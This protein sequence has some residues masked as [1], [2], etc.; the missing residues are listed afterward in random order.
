MTVEGSASLS[1]ATPAVAAGERRIDRIFADLRAAGRTGLMPFITGGF[2][3]LDATPALLA[4]MARSEASVVEVG[5]PFSDPIA[6]G[7]V[8]AASMHEALERGFRVPAL[9]DCIREL[10]P[11]LGGLGLV[12]M[13]S[14]S[15]VHRV[16]LPR[17]VDQAAEAG[18]DG[19]IFPD[20]PID[21]ATDAVAVAGRAGLT[22]S[23]LIAPTTPSDRAV[24]IADASSGFVYL[25]ARLGITGE[26]SDTPQI[27]ARM[28]ELRTRSALPV[29]CGFGIATAEAVRAVTAVADAAIVGS[30]LVRRM[31]EH[32]HEGGPMAELV[33]EAGAFVRELA[34]GLSVRRV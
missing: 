7:P 22:C 29:A 6:D 33:A 30:A 26:R 25:M 28:R 34:G 21:E 11:N 18:F 17:F 14:F 9:F 16:G 3:S 13:V 32:D 23:L 12:A 10:R 2:P 5:L 1:S 24:R 4:E 27:D 19:F 31:V 8:I 15:I 20:L